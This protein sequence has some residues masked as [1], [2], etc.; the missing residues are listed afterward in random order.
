LAIEATWLTNPDRHAYGDALWT[1]ASDGRRHR[2]ELFVAARVELA[3]LLCCFGRVERA[4]RRDAL[5]DTIASAHEWLIDYATRW[6]PQGSTPARPNFWSM[7]GAKVRWRCSHLRETHHTRHARWITATEPH[8]LAG[9]IEASGA[10]L[11]IARERVLVEQ[12][13]RQFADPQE[14]IALD[15]LAEGWCLAEAARR[16][17]LGRSRVYRLLERVNACLCSRSAGEAD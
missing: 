11:P 4:F 6:D 13:G 9:F 1:L 8:E 15:T 16:A 2:G 14:Q 7:V 17:G 5:T 3:G 12:L 10:H